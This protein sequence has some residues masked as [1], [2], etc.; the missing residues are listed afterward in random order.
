LTLACETRRSEESAEIPDPTI[1]TGF[2]EV[3]D[4]RLYYEVA[5]T[6][7]PIV[8]IHGN[9]LD[10]RNWD[11][12]FLPLSTRHRVIRF[13]VRGY[14][15]SSLP[16]DNPYTEHDDLKALLQHL[17][18]QRA[19]VVGLSMGSAIAVDFVLAFPE[20]SRSLTAAGP[21]LSG[22]SSDSATE[23]FGQWRE[24]P[25]VFAE[26]GAK[27][28]AEYWINTPAFRETV[29]DEAIRRRLIETASEWSFWTFT[30]RN[31]PRESLEPPALERL[32]QINVP[33]LII[34]AEYDLQSCKEVA[35][36]LEQK[37]G[38]ARKIILP[39]TGHV[40]N[41]EKP[42]EFNKVLLDFLDSVARGRGT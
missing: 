20:M 11:Q 19:H 8:F 18:V 7:D 2:V 21:W 27:A 28:A 23:V 22:Y 5:G 25:A 4:G 26:D 3:N 10:H 42:D 39:G 17:E 24:I 31:N 40:M 35:D 16:E 30:D 13:D 32:D 12:Q 36:L 33:T 15:R 37:V 29:R 6:G 1:E 9:G 14:G 34:T 38:G 41:M